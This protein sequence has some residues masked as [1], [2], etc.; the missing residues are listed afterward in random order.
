MIDLQSSIK[1]MEQV[2]SQIESSSSVES[3]Q[4]AQ[5]IKRIQDER[6]KLNSDLEKKK[7]ALIIERK[8]MLAD[9]VAECFND[10][11]MLND[12]FVEIFCDFLQNNRK[13]IINE[14]KE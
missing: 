9:A 8:I 4:T 13:K 5:K 14:I 10:E 6:L 7:S 12:K 2:R 11:I 3:M 1:K